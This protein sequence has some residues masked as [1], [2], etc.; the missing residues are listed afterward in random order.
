MSSAKPK[1]VRLSSEACKSSIY[2]RCEALQQAL[3]SIKTA[4]RELIEA[5]DSAVD[6][7]ALELIEKGITRLGS[8]NT[9]FKYADLLLTHLKTPDGESGWKYL[10]WLRQEVKA[11]A[12]KQ[13]DRR[14]K[15]ARQARTTE[16]HEQMGDE[17]SALQVTMTLQ[18][19]AYLWLIKELSGV[20]ASRATEPATRQRLLNLL[21]NHDELFGH[22]F[23]PEFDA[24]VRP[25]NVAEIRQS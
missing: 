16:R 14:S 18:T 19:K 15:T 8:R 4:P 24:D 11:A 12:A 2:S 22:L 25:S 13:I 21:N 9:L 3:K 5:C 7:A 23:S 6:L 1:R 10:D 20:A 17:L